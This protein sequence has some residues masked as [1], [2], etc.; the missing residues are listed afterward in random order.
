MRINEIETAQSARNTATISDLR[1]LSKTLQFQRKLKHS[2]DV[3]DTFL[4]G[5]NNPVI[6]CGGG[7][8][9]T[10]VALL[11]KLIGAKVGIVCANPPN[12]L[13]DREAHVQELRNWLGDTWTWTSVPYNWDVEAVLDGKA[14]Y[15]E[16]LK[17]RRL[18]NFLWR[19][20]VDGV[21]FGIRAAE[22][23]ARSINLAMNGE[24]YKLQGGGYRC[25]P[26]ARWTAEDSLCLALL[27]DAPINPV[28]LKMDGTGGLEQ[29]HDGTWWPHG[30][31]DRSG[32]IKKYYPDYYELYERALKI[33]PSQNECRY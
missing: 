17:M 4:N 11:G 20:N 14:E 7:K 28:Y 22:S 1:K 33:G 16:G 15:P 18:E 2:L 21:I 6:S 13:P 29:L 12:P 23:R 26:I 25:Q 27:M 19:E 3:M 10:A 31:Q 32:W 8:D 30:L 24:I 5:V 9:G